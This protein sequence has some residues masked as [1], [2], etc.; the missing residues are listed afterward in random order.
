VYSKF[1]FL[2][3]VVS[4]LVVNLDVGDGG[5]KMVILEEIAGT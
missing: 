5:E 3:L 1:V 2:G 4:C